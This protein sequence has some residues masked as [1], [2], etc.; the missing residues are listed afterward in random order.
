MAK[1]K[2][3][4]W[5]K[6]LCLIFAFLLSIESFAAV[7]SDNDGSAFITKAEF[8]SLKNDFQSQIDQYN[9]SIDNKIDGAI[10]SYL[11]SI[12]TPKTSVPLLFEWKTGSANKPICVY[13]GYNTIDLQTFQGGVIQHSWW[14]NNGS[15]FT[16]FTPMTLETL[17]EPN[18]KNFTLFNMI[19]EAYYD[20]MKGYVFDENDNEI[21]K[22][23]YNYDNCLLNLSFQ[24][25]GNF[26]YGLSG[27]GDTFLMG[28]IPGT[29][30]SKRINTSYTSTSGLGNG[31]GNWGCGRN[32]TWYN[33]FA[34]DPGT[35][36]NEW[37]NDI[38]FTQAFAQSKERYNNGTQYAENCFS[39]SYYVTES[40][41]NED[42]SIYL[43]NACHDVIYAHSNSEDQLEEYEDYMD[44]INTLPDAS[45]RKIGGTKTNLYMS[46][47][48]TSWCWFAPKY[49]SGGWD[50][51]N[52]RSGKRLGD[53]RHWR[54]LPKFKLKN[55][56]TVVPPNTPS[57]SG[58]TN[59]WN[60]LDQFKNSLL[61]FN[62][63]NGTTVYPHYYGGLPLISIGQRAIEEFTF[64][65]IIE[66]TTT[67]GT[68]PTHANIQVKKDEF[69]NNNNTSTWSTDDK[70]NLVEIK[71]TVNN[72][73][74]Q[75][76]KTNNCIKVPLNQRVKIKMEEPPQKT[77]LFLRFWEDGNT[78]RA[79]G[80]IV[81]IGNAI[82]MG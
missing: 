40:K 22:N 17:S 67:S 38:P 10:A 51:E 33:S 37:A 43:Y 24:S 25:T 31:S 2:R 70:E 62:D 78:D 7:V 8:D 47:K 28:M 15:K 74:I 71:A 26:N 75:Y 45:S 49:T 63:W 27:K 35:V 59:Y 6:A 82:E 55:T 36:Y 58:G 13:D 11:A 81:E 76:D 68:I 69:P 48:T 12:A 16:G 19:H 60:T 80:R 3:K 5:K 66:P 65:I 61:K 39:A 72:T 77:T 21:I 42:K 46:G 79:G 52:Q 34:G 50:Y 4:M 29:F 9:T 64:E 23:K 57:K 1:T 20:Q 32:E 53:R 44:K 54:F 14:T 41:S 18:D 56:S 73:E 30:Q